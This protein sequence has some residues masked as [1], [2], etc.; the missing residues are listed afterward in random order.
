MSRFQLKEVAYIGGSILEPG[1]HELPDDTPEAK[2]L[3]NLTKELKRQEEAKAKAAKDAE[4][5]AAAKAKEEAT[6]KAK[7]EKEAAKAAKAAE[8]PTN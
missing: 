3:V 7:A 2:H 5:A 6:A 8:N 4:E 1:E